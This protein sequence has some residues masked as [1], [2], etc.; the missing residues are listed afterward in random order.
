MNNTKDCIKCGATF[1][2][3]KN[4]SL[5][6]WNEKRK[7]CSQKCY[8]KW[9]KEDRQLTEE[10]RAHIL[11]IG[12]KGRFKKGHVGYAA[13]KGRKHSKESLLK[14]SKSHKKNPTKYWLGKKRTEMSGEKHPLWKGGLT[15]A[16]GYLLE[17][18]PE[19]PNSTKSGYVRQH[20][21]VAE[22]KI[23]RFLKENELVHHKDGDKKNNSEEN[24]EVMSRSEHMK[25]HYGERI[26]DKNGRLTTSE[27]ISE[28]LKL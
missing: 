23:G 19:H 9:Q 1:E 16:D 2:K 7:F 22:K 10:Q 25:L 6:E 28:K 21:L 14:M 4:L 18:N 20:R 27:T 12:K 11:K 5:E 24:L 15:E 8:W 13:M 3:P 17:H 26:I